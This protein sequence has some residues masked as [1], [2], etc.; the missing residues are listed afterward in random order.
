M[1]EETSTSSA[2]QGGQ[3]ELATWRPISEAPFVRNRYGDEPQQTTL[4]LNEWFLLA[5]RDEHGWVIW[6]GTLDA[7]EWIGR[8]DQRG[9]WDS[10]APTHFMQLPTPPNFRDV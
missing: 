1:A 5:R 4:E 10:T 8:D 9:C 2:H 6:V 7:D 3:P